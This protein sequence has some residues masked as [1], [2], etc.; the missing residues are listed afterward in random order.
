MAA[1][2]LDHKTFS[3]AVTVIATASTFLIAVGVVLSDAVCQEP[4]GLATPQVRRKDRGGT[5][6][7]RW[8]FRLKQQR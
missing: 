3:L 2:S 6:L 8:K 5:E 7:N 1:F 4:E